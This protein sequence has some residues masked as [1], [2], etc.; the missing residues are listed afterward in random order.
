MNWV[1]SLALGFMELPKRLLSF[2]TKPVPQEESTVEETQLPCLQ[3]AN[4][5]VLGG[6]F[7]RVERDG[8]ESSVGKNCTT[9][10]SF[11]KPPFTPWP[12]PV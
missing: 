8:A 5:I 2:K 1:V 12:V 10:N 9:L 11:V 4:C 7:T 3:K 6:P